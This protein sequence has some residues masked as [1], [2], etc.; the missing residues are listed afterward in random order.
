MIVEDDLA[1]A[2][3]VDHACV[4][5]VGLDIGYLT[6]DVDMTVQVQWGLKDLVQPAKGFDALV[7]TVCHVLDLPGW[8]MADEDIQKTTKDQFI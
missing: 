4:V 5:K 2:E 3:S 1:V 7:W 8:G 6:V